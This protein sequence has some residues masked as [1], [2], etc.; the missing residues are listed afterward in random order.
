MNLYTFGK[1]LVKTALTPLYRFE[2]TG[3]EKFPDQGGILLCANHIHA[4]DPPVVGMT[5]PRT[6]H[7]MAKEELFKVP[8]LGRI[9]PQVNAFPVK[10]GMSDREAL[11]SALKLLKNG[12]VV[13]LF[14][15]GTRSTDGV[16]KKG[17]SGAGF[18]ALR[19]NADVMPCAIIG[20]YKPF[21]KV[22]VVYGEP[23]L[24]EPYRERKASVEEVTA[25][26]MASI[27]KL[28][29]ENSEK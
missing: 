23:V 11:R 5:S 21:R 22:K 4:L 10:R 1:A 7:F 6:V 3:T 29:D 9:L 25:V 12:E 13:G 14:P 19:G 20:P 15:E 26:I 27:Q 28:L 18:F 16:L 17:L 24:M 2:V 8:V